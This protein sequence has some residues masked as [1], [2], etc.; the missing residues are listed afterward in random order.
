MKFSSPRV[1]PKR[2]SPKTIF[3]KLALGVML[4]PLGYALG[5]WGFLLSPLGFHVGFIGGSC[6]ARVLG[7]RGLFDTNN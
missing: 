6:W 3:H 2:I 5:P 7:P 4:G 1:S